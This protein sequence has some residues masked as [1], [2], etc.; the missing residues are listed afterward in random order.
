MSLSDM[1]HN[2]WKLHLLDVEIMSLEEKYQNLDRG[3]ELKKR[4]NFLSSLYNKKTDEI[5]KKEVSLKELEIELSSLE[6]RKKRDEER[7]YKNV[8]TQKEIDSLTQEIQHIL[9]AKSTV[10]DKILELMESLEQLKSEIPQIKKEIEEL[11]VQ[12]K[13][14]ENNAKIAENEIADKLH[15]LIAEREERL[16]DIDPKLLN[17]YELIR[18]SRRGKGMARVIDNRCSECGVELSISIIEELRLQ[19]KIVT[20]EHCGRIL[21]I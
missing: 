12:L 10:E 17:K 19:E 2:L 14:T 16:K 8:T 15:K 4:I 21:C 11:T 20:C 13:E 1:L 9:E 7:L 6:D 5:K 18:K 3:E